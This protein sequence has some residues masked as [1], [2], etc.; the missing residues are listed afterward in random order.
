M[1]CMEDRL[2]SQFIMAKH[3]NKLKQFLDE[4]GGLPRQYSNLAVTVSSLH[5]VNLFSN[6]ILYQLNNVY[7]YTKNVPAIL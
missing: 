6:L 3:A 1:G 2:R 7:I 5:I 4:K